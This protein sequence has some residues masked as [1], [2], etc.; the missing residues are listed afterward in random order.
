MIVRKQ[1]NGE[2]LLIGQTDH[3]RLAGHLAAHWGND[4]FAAPDPG[5]SVVR[6]AAFHDYGW[7]PYESSP[8]LNPTT[9]EPYQFL[10]LPI[11]VSQLAA[12]QWG[13]DWLA[14]IDPYAGL[15]VS[16]HRTGLW[17]SRYN[18]I[19][20]PKGYVPTSLS[21]E[22][23]AFIK[24]NEGRQERDRR[25]W[26]SKQLWINYRLMQV[27]DILSLYFCCADSSEEQI[28]PVPVNYSDKSGIL[29]TIKPVGP[30][31]VSCVPYPFDVHPLH[32]QLLC[33]RLRKA[34]Y[35]NVSEFRRAYSGGEQ[36]LCKFEL[37]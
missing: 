5:D 21:E 26:N 30:A 32:V 23:Q 12:Y 29:M 34:T 19:T 33:K 13:L 37:T 15:I 6:A 8:L 20:R 36:E 25:P 31:Q 35:E 4:K 24:E 7:L 3:S 22:I 10:Q 14:E 2:L 17:Q 18:M 1:P 9:G 11:G 28:E 27:W 16:M